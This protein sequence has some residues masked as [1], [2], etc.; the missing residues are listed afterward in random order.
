MRGAVRKL[1]CATALVATFVA[2][3]ASADDATD[4]LEDPRDRNEW[5]GFPVV[6]GSTD[7]GVQ[8]GAA[9]TVT[10][11]GDRFKPYWWKIDG[12]VSLSVKGG[13][14]GTEIV[15]Q[16]HDM[17][18]DIPGGGGGEIRLMPAVFYDKTINSGYFGLGN[19]ARVVAN[20]DGS[21]GDRYQFRHEEISTR[22]N[23]RT[24]LG[25][26]PFSAMYGWQLRYVTP[27]AYPGS[28]LAIDAATRLSDGR[29]L[30]YG[31]R[32]LGIATLN[33]G[34][35]YDTRDDEIFPKK[36]EF[37]LGAWRIS[38]GVPTDASVYWAGVS[39]VLRKYMKLPGPFVLAGRIIVDAMAGHV[40]FYDLSQGLAFDP[41]DM[42]GGPEGVRGVPNGRYS[43]LFKVVGNIEE[44]AII[45][46]FRFL[47][48]KFQVGQT[49][50]F[51]GGR[52]W[53]DYTFTDVRDGS[54]VGVKYG[55]GGGP[56]LIWNTAALFRIDVAYSPDA[57]AANPGFPVGIYVQEGFIF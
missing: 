56:F 38:G 39:V 53:N 47:G 13:P 31:L 15:Q 8:L 52:V 11:V 48:Q 40:P 20:P 49:A 28:R 45:G 9:A 41:D 2:R 36:G 24:P 10:H 12:L 6:G 22:L 33:A 37:L 16:S 44:R 18:F 26:G 29:P 19:A 23:V 46:G 21:I 42:P 17:R 50:F 14:R 57:S 43:G 35:I 25:N 51:D 3:T 27:K 34:I 5:A 32:P 4:D 55:V 54:G 7:I 1:A 30:V